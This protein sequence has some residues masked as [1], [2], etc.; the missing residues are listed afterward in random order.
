MKIIIDAMGGM[1]GKLLAVIILTG[2][3]IYKAEALANFNLYIIPICFLINILISIFFDI[4]Y[5]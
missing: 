1:I 4:I 5:I 2:G 3:K